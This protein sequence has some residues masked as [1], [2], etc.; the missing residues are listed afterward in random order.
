VT[1]EAAA[2]LTAR[3]LA[4]FPLPP[5]GR[6]P[7]GPWRT[8]VLTDPGRVRELWRDGDNIG[9]GCRASRVIGLDLDIEGDGQAVLAALASRLCQPWPETLTVATPSG[10][11]HLYFAAPDGCTIGSFSGHRSPLG[12]GIDVRG[13]GLR[14]GG[15]LVGPG[16]VV[17]GR[18]YT[19][20]RDVPMFPLPAWLARLL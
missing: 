5:G 18:P 7:S 10:G 3:G 20:A 4:V 19:I 2:D 15:Y 17:G 8:Q 6:L 13:P 1:T 14:T 16:S 12:P 9:I 11:R